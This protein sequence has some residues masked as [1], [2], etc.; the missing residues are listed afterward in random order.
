M[1]H[2]RWFN[3]NLVS[4]SLL[5]AAISEVISGSGTRLA[6]VASAAIA[7]NLLACIADAVEEK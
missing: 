7:L 6:L 5:C 2:M 1:K 4:V 3:V